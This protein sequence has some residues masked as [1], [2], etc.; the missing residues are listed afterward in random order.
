MKKFDLLTLLAAAA[1]IG[2]SNAAQAGPEA[3]AAVELNR[4]EG[5]YYNTSNDDGD[6]GSDAVGRSDLFAEPDFVRRLTVLGYDPDTLSGG[7]IVLDFNDNL[8]LDGPSTD[9]F[10]I[11]GGSNESVFVEVSDDR[12]D[13]FHG[14]GEIAPGNNF[15]VDMAG[16]V[17]YF[18]R[19]RL[20]ATDTAGVAQT[21]GFD[22]DAVVC[23]NSID[24]PAFDASYEGCDLKKGDDGLDIKQV[25][26]YSDDENI[27]VDMVLCGP[28][29]SKATYSVHFDYAGG[30][31]GGPDALEGGDKC[32]AAEDGTASYKNGQGETL[33]GAFT[34]DGNRLSFA[35]AYGNLGLLPGDEVL[36]WLESRGKGGGDLV[37]NAEE[38]D[39]CS[40]PQ[41]A[42]EALALTLRNEPL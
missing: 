39:K 27:Y 34:A 7:N 37:P 42:A 36:I 15:R 28:V 32:V 17:N 13:T 24:R 38:G 33:G 21:S 4:V 41:I 40:R 5:H 14:V 25:V 11:D 6:D 16:A 31:S 3:D 10:A 26:T 19:I 9:V 8:C 30:A 18:N 12:G 2:G 20:I 1:L 22:L 35:I 23:L 29:A